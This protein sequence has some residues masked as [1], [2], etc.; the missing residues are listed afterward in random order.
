MSNAHPN[1]LPVALKRRRRAS[2]DDAAAA[3]SAPCNAN[4]CNQPS[5]SSELR[6]NHAHPID[7]V[8]MTSAAPPRRRR[9]IAVS[10]SVSR[11]PSPAVPSRSSSSSDL[12]D[13][14]C[15][16]CVRQ[17]RLDERFVLCDKCDAFTACTACWSTCEWTKT[18]LWGQQRRHLRDRLEMFPFLG[19]HDFV[20]EHS[21]SDIEPSDYSETTWA[22]Y[23]AALLPVHQP[24][25]QAPRSLLG[26]H[27][28]RA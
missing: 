26:L 19:Q 22:E 17:L 11:S 21:R 25:Q 18:K 14:W 15:F 24:S 13:I 7:G 28:R 16:Y 2:D 5:E 8:P 27:G 1:T 6:A 9:R 23:E 10:P 3:A 20:K 12:L 4:Q